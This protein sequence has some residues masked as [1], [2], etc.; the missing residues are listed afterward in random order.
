MTIHNVNNYYKRLTFSKTFYNPVMKNTIITLSAQLAPEFVLVNNKNSAFG[1][2]VS[3]KGKIYEP[4]MTLHEI[5]DS[6]KSH[7][8][9]SGEAFIS[10]EGCVGFVNTQGHVLKTV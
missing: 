2:V 9:T 6:S 3:Y 1:F 5:T 7:Y 4:D 8:Q 10:D